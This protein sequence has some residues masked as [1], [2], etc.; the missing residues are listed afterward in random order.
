[1]RVFSRISAA[2]ILGGMAAIGS[3]A[4]ATATFAQF[5]QVIPHARIFTYTNVTSGPI[6]AKLGTIA[7]SNTVLVS[8]LGSLASPTLARINLVGTATALPTVSG[9]IRQLFSGTLTFTLLAPQVGMSGLSTNALDVTFVDAALLVA[10]ATAS[11][12]TLQA[13]SGSGSAI[14]YASDFADLSG[15]TSQDF[16][17]SFSGASVPLF[18]SGSR[19]PDFRVSGSG[20]IAAVL[21]LP[22]PASWGLMLGGFAA[23]GLA[24]RRGRAG[25]RKS[26]SAERVSLGRALSA[27]GTGSPSHRA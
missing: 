12:P 15:T 19:L 27:G 24:L 11:A 10:P 26:R 25:R 5:L 7:A 23:I 14:T 8:N 22:E 6:S 21:P 20:T 18:I 9:D 13:S 3:P 17:L 1:M 4:Q 16:S 2:A